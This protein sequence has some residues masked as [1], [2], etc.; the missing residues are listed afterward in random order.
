MPLGVDAPMSGALRRLAGTGPS[1]AFLVDL[2]EV[3]A[4]GGSACTIARSLRSLP[5]TPADYCLPVY[6]FP[7]AVSVAS[8]AATN[9][10]SRLAGSVALAFSLT[11]WLLPG[12][13]KKL[14]PAL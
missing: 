4:E 13:S 10:A 1:A 5:P 6:C 2:G 12:G 3:G 11:R 9:T 14:S 7:G 8:S